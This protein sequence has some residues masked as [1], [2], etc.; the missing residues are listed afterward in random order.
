MWRKSEKTTPARCQTIKTSKPLTSNLWASSTQS[1]P[2]Y[3]AVGN[4]GNNTLSGATGDDDLDGGDGDDLLLGA[5]GNDDLTSSAGND[6]LSGGQGDD[7]YHVSGGHVQIEDYLGHDTLDTS[8]ATG[9]SHIDLSGETES[10]IENE[11]CHIQGGG[12]TSAPLDVQF[13]QD[14]SGSFADDIATV[15]GVIPGSISALQAVQANSMFGVSSFIDKPIAPFGA[16]GEWVYAQHMALGTNAAALSATYDAMTTLNGADGPEAQIEGLMQLGLHAAEVGFR[17]DSARFVV[18]FTDAPYHVAG[19][20][21]LGG[22]TTPNNGDAFFPGN[23]ALEDYPTIAQLMSAL[24]LANIIPIFAVAGRVEASYQTPADQLGRGAVVSLTANSSNIVTAITTGLTAATTTHIEDAC[25]GAGNDDIIGSTDDNRLTGTAGN[26]TLS[27][28]GGHD[29]LTG[30]AGADTLEGGSGDDDLT[31]GADSDTARYTGARADY[32]VVAV[33][34]G[35]MITD[36]RIGVTDGVDTVSGVELFAFS[37]G[38]LTVAQ[39]LGGAAPVLS[40]VVDTDVAA[41]TVPENSAAGTAVGLDLE[42]QDGTGT[43]MATSFVL[44]TDATGTTVSS[45][46]RFP[47]DASTGVV[48]VRDGTQLNFEAAASQTI[49]VRT[50]RGDGTAIVTSHVIA[51]SDLFE[52]VTISQTLTKLADV[53]TAPT[54]D[55]YIVV[56]LAGADVITTAGGN[57][58]IVGGAG[59]DTIST[60]DGADVIRVSGIKHDYDAVNGGAGLDR[61]EATTTGT[62][63]GF[64]A[65]S[66]IEA[67]T[68]NGLAG[69]FIRGNAVANVLDFSGTVLTGI[70]SIA[71]GG[72]AD[73]IIG[74][75]GADTIAGGLGADRLTGGAG[76]DV[77]RF[78]LISESKGAAFDTITDFAHLTDQI[79]LSAI[80]ANTLL[81]D[82]QAFSFIGT[83]AFGHVA[84]EVRLIIGATGETRIIGD[85]NGDGKTDFD[86]HLAP[87]GGLA[88]GITGADFLL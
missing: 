23:G 20:G 58:L 55:H 32:D 49:F 70:T 66:G 16:A 6:T 86:I 8:D 62:A 39:M 27:G 33:P 26:D 30:D 37:D 64:S 68:A 24:T 57:D 3:I 2:K 69:V 28:R 71:G 38:N 36:L 76:A 10:Q 50:T 42:G 18:L 82:D 81:A 48:T 19:D 13:L 60:G 40:A 12:S 88:V 5:A 21:V 83:A 17:P 61:I 46:G 72:G 80:D 87:L 77:F 15:R 54:D 14:R 45:T 59:N 73:T 29:V 44:V 11:I 35:P 52:P 43:A 51:V 63:I 22:I 79:D 34:G 7:T 41:D 25:G 74:S 1:T 78:N 53:I 47:I 31:G 56:G 67:I 85:V 65:V 4:S 9:D 84:G 75:A